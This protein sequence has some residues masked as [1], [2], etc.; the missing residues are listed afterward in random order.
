[1]L[2]ESAGTFHLARETA[3]LL[4]RVLNAA[5]LASRSWKPLI[6]DGNPPQ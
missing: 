2:S 3:W 6:D 4:I 1:M 5:L